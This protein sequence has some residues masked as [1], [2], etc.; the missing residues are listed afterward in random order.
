MFSD[1]CRWITDLMNMVVHML[2]SNDWCNGV[3]LLGTNFSARVLVLH[4][5]LFK[6][7]LDGT[8]VTMLNLTLL[9]SR[10]SM[11]V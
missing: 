7:S 5:L 2:A 11:G 1:F 4:T 10:H 3:G 6:T 8:R 9:N